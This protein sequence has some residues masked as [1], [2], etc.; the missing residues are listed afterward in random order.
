MIK[1]WTGKFGAIVALMIALSLGF[2]ESA[3]AYGGSWGSSRGGFGSGGGS[4]GGGNLGGGGLLAG[5][6]PLR[7]LLGIFGSGISAI[8][9]GIE[10]IS[11]IGGNGSMGSNGSRGGLLGG[12]LRNGLF[13]G[14][15]LGGGSTGGWGS[16]GSTGSFAIGGSSTGYSSTGHYDSPSAYS[17]WSSGMSYDSGPSYGSTGGLYHGTATE[18]YYGDWGASYLSGVSD[19]SY[20]ISTL[21]ASYPANA[22]DSYDSGLVYGNIED[23]YSSPISSVEQP[24]YDSGSIY[25]NSGSMIGNTLDSYGVPGAIETG[26]DAPVLDYGA[27]PAFGPSFDNS[28]QPQ[29]G[30]IYG[31]L[32]TGNAPGAG[33]GFGDGLPDAPIPDADADSTEFRQKDSEAIL[34][35]KLPREAKVYINGKL[36]KTSGTLRQ[37]VS[38]NLTEDKDYRY[39]VKAVIEK[40]GRE[41]V[42]TQLVN[43][44]PGKDRLVRFNFDQPQITTLVLKVPVDAEVLLDGRKTKAK[45]KIRT[46]ST[47]KLSNEQ[48][49]NDYRIE[50]RYFKDGKQF[51]EQRALDLVAGAK[52]I[53]AMGGSS[54]GLSAEA[55]N[56]AIAQN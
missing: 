45:G 50:V 33:S 34:S 2:S 28:S 4:W 7:N 17:T 40:D 27:S 30:Q 49:W 16:A 25:N 55:I 48:T 42:R 53:I 47:R 6:R 3:N 26:Y 37:Y 23:A 12:A 20:P 14:G 18:D 38:R 10:N 56:T 36:T 32:D 46:F 44:R 22:N 43:M 39:R 29:P 13:G 5:R 19:F 11:Q 21:D 35:L 54:T 8:G 52:E 51:V 24:I 41:V 15:L 9:N 31:P 1:Q